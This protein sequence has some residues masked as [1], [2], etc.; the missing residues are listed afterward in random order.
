MDHVADRPLAEGLAVDVTDMSSSI[1][2]LRD[3]DSPP[4]PDLSTDKPIRVLAISPNTVIQQS[5][6]MRNQRNG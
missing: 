1:S 4:A 2:N 6:S 5:D 3:D